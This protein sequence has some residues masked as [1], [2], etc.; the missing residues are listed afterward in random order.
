MI[1]R[2]DNSEFCLEREAFFRFVLFLHQHL[3]RE[4]FFFEKKIILS[5]AHAFNFY[6][7]QKKR[8]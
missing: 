6:F 7:T 4:Q 5:V 3:H 8:N 2:Q 1:I